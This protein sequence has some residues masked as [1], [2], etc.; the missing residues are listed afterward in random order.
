MIPICLVTGFLGSGKTTLLK[1]ISRQ[2]ADRRLVYLVNE[3]SA[4]VD[5]QIVSSLADDVVSVAGGSIFCQCKVTE[6]I[7]QLRAIA[8]RFDRNRFEGVV[9]EASG[10]ADPKVIRQ[11]LRE[12]QLAD[13]YRVARVVAMV[14]PG[15]FGKLLATLPN[16]AS[17]IEAADLAL[18]NKCDL[19]DEQ[20]IADT[21]AGIRRINPGIE[22]VRACFGEASFD[23]FGGAGLA[24][25]QGE[26]AKC[27]D[28]NY[29]KLAVRLPDAVSLDRLRAIFD[30]LGDD[31]YR[32]KGFVR[33]DEGWAYVDHAAGELRIEAVASHDYPAQ[34]AVIIRPAAA[35]RARAKLNALQGNEHEPD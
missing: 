2:S 7:G 33:V 32:A 15:T 27:I 30:D 14:D 12:A 22:T 35:Q 26:M 23:L 10:I 34:L 1:A 18:I 4:D 25:V 8:R 5:G 3:F 19:H 13:A 17:Q 20:A 16:I 21:E 11:M 29:A 31:L 28:P 24:D 9:I 6:F